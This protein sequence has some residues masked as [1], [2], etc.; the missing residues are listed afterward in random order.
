MSKN[1][2]TYRYFIKLL[3][4]GFA[5]PFFYEV[6]TEEFDRFRSVLA[7][8][9]QQRGEKKTPNL[10]MFHTVNQLVVGVS[11]VAIQLAHFLFERSTTRDPDED[12]GDID[13]D[14]SHVHLWRNI[15]VALFSRSARH[16]IQ[17]PRSSTITSP[18]AV[19]VNSVCASPAGK[20]AT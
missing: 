3:V 12:N 7:D 19:T 6:G 9:P 8:L 14:R 20:C 4:R 15:Y 5:P 11:P 18:T 16:A 2:N 1:G 10:F 13:P 17:L